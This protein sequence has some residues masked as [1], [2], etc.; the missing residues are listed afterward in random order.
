MLSCVAFEHPDC[1][2]EFPT[3]VPVAGRS[4]RA[5]KLLRMRLKN[6]R[7]GANHFPALASGVA[8]RAHLI[9]PAMGS[10]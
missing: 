3:V 5:E 6:H 1:S 8:R 9:K 7:S 2:L 4:E 10:G